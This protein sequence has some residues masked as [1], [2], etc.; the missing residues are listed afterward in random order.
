MH[1]WRYWPLKVVVAKLL[2]TNIL[3]G[4]H[5]VYTHILLLCKHPLLKEHAKGTQIQAPCSTIKHT[6]S[7]R[8]HRL[9][10]FKWSLYLR[11]AITVATINAA[12]IS[13]PKR[14]PTMIPAIILPAPV[15]VCVCVWGGGGVSGC[16]TVRIL[17][18]YTEVVYKQ[19][20]SLI[21]G[22][23]THTRNQSIP[24]TLTVFPPG[25]VVV[26]RGPDC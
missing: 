10:L 20:V 12:I 2:P 7:S 18:C 1:A 24:D 21:K 5:L 16:M 22:Q 15:C 6:H 14:T 9:C 25:A 8:S 19:L 3:R 4:L 17:L 11:A 23:H 13:N 26:I